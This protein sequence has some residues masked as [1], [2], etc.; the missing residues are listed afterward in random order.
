MLNPVDYD[1]HQSSVYAKGRALPAE[2]VAAWMSAFSR[3]AAPGRPLSVLDLGSGTGRFTPALAESFGGPVYG[4]EPSSGMRQAAVADAGHPAVAYLDGSAGAIPLPDASVD[5]VLVFLVWHHVPDKAVAAAEI[6]R[7]LRTGGRVL[8]RSTFGDRLPEASWLDYF[9]TA[10]AVEAAMF[11]TLSQVEAE[12]TDAGLRRI[13]LEV[14]RIQTVESAEAY[15]RRLRMKAI[16]TFEHLPEDEIER[17]FARMD[18][19][20]ASGTPAFR[21]AEDGDLLVFESPAPSAEACCR[22]GFV[23]KSLPS[24]GTRPSCGELAKVELEDFHPDECGL[25]LVELQPDA[26][27]IVVF[28]VDPNGSGR[29]R[30]GSSQVAA[31]G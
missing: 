16:S 4:V 27:F 2:V 30:G 5:L 9:P 17:G 23:K 29:I 25:V 21:L 31:A 12:F 18:A 11:P 13:A 15:V 19:D 24:P 14:V 22:P 20:V 1:G 8:F 10:A 7:V 28:D 6:R 3:H 26:R